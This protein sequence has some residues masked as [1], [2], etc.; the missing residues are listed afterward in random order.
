MAANLISQVE[1]VYQGIQGAVVLNVEVSKE[2][3]VENVTVLSG[4]P[5]LTQAA[6]DAVKQWRYKPT[7]LN[8]APV[9]VITEV[10]V[11]FPFSAGAQA[12]SPSGPGQR[13]GR[14]PQ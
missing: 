1:P 12:P 13:R 2:G 8:G 10:R 14:G 5:Q 6:I 3:T 4:P 9:P 11:T 7:L